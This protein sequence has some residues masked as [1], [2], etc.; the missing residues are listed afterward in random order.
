MSIIFSAESSR[1]LDE[2]EKD[3]NGGHLLESIWSAIDLITDN[4]DSASARRRALR[5]PGGHTIWLVPI[6]THVEGEQWVILW[7]P[8]GDDI[9]IP[10]IGSDDFHS[11]K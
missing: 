9:L 6:P 7:Q 5:T 3:A 8:R 4:P 10:Y 1:V 11:T 2:L